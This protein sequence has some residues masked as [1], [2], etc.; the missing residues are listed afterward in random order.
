MRSGYKHA[1]VSYSFRERLLPSLT[2]INTLQI[3][4]GFQIQGIVN[5]NDFIMRIDITIADSQLKLFTRPS[6]PINIKGVV[7]TDLRGY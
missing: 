1:H 5:I 2:L 3:V 4:K 6:Q 7:I